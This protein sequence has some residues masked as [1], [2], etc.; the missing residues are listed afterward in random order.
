MNYTPVFS[1][2]NSNKMLE[3]FFNK[4][5][6]LGES[7]LWDRK[8]K[9]L[10]WIDILDNKIYAFNEKRFYEFNYSFYISSI[11]LTN[12]GNLI[13][14][15]SKGILIINPFKN[16]K[17][18]VH[19]LL[20]FPNERGFNRFNDGKI[21]YQGNFILG[22]MD[23]NEIKKSGNLY[24]IN[25]RGIKLLDQGYRICNGPAFS[26]DGKKMYFSDSLNQIIYVFDYDSDGGK[27]YNKEIFTFFSKKG[28]F[29]DGLTVDK[30]GHLWCAVYGGSRIQRY[31]MNGKARETIDLPVAQITSCCF[32]GEANKYLFITSA[33]KEKSRKN[34]Q[35]G[36]VFK[37]KTKVKGIDSNRYNEER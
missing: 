23:K 21:D 7:P 33:S 31:S 29:P 24:Q 37:Y 26:P 25:N 2:V 4:N 11:G 20:K 17:K 10:Y 28:E 15:T 36:F 22:S 1:I 19:N 5:L 18:I 8:K 35:N 12:R 9:I 16:E 32:G 27:I 30:T 14:A 6:L 34:G 13:C 3:I